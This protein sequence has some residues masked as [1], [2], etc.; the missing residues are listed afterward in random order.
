MNRLQQLLEFLKEDPDDPFTLYAIATEY[1]QTDV[2]QARR[3]FEILLKS[4]PN[5]VP[6]YYHAA[7]LYEAFDEKDLAIKTYEKGIQQAS[8][9]NENLALRELKNA[10]QEILFD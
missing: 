6:T 3:Y 10:Y 1:L 4:H 8:E 7:K 9:Q 5:Y 2:E